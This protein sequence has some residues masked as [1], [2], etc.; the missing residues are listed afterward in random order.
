MFICK[1]QNVPSS[2][3]TA[4]ENKKLE[5]AYEKQMIEL[6]TGNSWKYYW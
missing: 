6:K 2:V 4:L 5:V 3:I 1:Q